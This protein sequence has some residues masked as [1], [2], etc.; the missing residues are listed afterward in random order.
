[1]ALIKWAK[2]VGV[3]VSFPELL[4]SEENGAVLGNLL[5]NAEQNTLRV[6]STCPTKLRQQVVSFGYLHRVLF[7]RE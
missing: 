7:D 4:V 1:M 6:H 3:P 5:G 2:R